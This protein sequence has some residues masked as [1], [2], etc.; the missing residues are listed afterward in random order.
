MAQA[1]AG[2]AGRY[3]LGV[4]PQ[5]GHELRHWQRRAQQ[6]PDPALR[7][8]ALSTLRCERGNLEGAAAFA[9]LA[10]RS[11]RARVVRAA[12]AFQATYDYVDSL[13]EQPCDDPAA[14]GEQLHLALLSA[15]QPRTA[16]PDYY[17]CNPASQD[18]GYIRQ[19]IDT[20]RGALAALPSYA[21]VAEGVLRAVRRM[22]CYQ[23]LHHS[24]A[25]GPLALWAAGVTPLGSGLHWWE[26]GAGTASS[27]GVFALFA[28]AGRP[29]LAPAEAHALEAAYFPW[30]GTL[31]V[32]L[33]SLIDR[34]GD[35][36]SGQH[37]LVGHYRSVEEGAARLSEIAGRAVQATEQ[38]SQSV[39]HAMILAAM[40]SFYLSS[41]EASTPPVELVTARVLETM[42]T[43]STP[44]MLVL[45]TRRTAARLG[46]AAGRARSA[47]RTRNSSIGLSTCRRAGARR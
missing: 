40:T 33:D 37:S 42:G 26:T 6:I 22:S 15:V 1:F 31:H 7:R 13:A 17:R 20:C 25:R 36:E 35:I 39:Q 29:L 16:H 38:L 23:A 9:V 30:I 10:P 14:N 3:W 21:I 11:M 47:G 45:R 5:V 18:N 4:F 24:S 34:S 19:L 2:A 8:A 27:L 12:V 46:D 44:T 43:L 32:L 41:P 28:A